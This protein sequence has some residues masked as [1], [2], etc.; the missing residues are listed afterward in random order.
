MVDYH[1]KEKAPL[2]GATSSEGF[3]QLIVAHCTLASSS[4]CRRC[5]HPNHVLWDSVLLLRPRERWRS[6][7]MSMSVCLCLSVCPRGYLR[8]HTR[9]LYQFFCACCL[10]PWLGPPPAGWRNPTGK[11]N[12]GQLSGPFKGNLLCSLRCRVRC[13]RDHSIANNVTQQKGSFSMPGKC[14]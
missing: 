3:L 6:T 5:R 2:T 9:D 12:F 13:K 14:K 8:N 11:G 4:W 1:I 7:V 10:W